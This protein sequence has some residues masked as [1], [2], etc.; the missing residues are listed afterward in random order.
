MIPSEISKINETLKDLISEGFS[1][2]DALENQTKNLRTALDE[3]N[4]VGFTINDIL[5]T[6][7]T[8]LLDSVRNIEKMGVNI[9]EIA[10]HTT[11]TVD[12]DGVLG[13]VVKKADPCNS[14]SCHR[15]P[16]NSPALKGYRKGLCG[17][18]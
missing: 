15:Y 5:E 11:E 3:L 6:S 8:N 7:T 12:N 16:H 10:I 4:Q 13:E 2:N 18:L 1:L 14:Q 9:K 17:S